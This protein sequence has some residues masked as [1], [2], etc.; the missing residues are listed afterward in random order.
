MDLKKKILIE[1]ENVVSEDRIF[2]TNTSSL[3]I[4]ELSNAAKR[5]QVK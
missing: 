2:A 4:T 5:P 3:S 1:I